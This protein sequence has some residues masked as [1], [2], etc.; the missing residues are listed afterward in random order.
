MEIQKNGK[1][2]MMVHIKNKYIILSYTKVALRFN[3]VFITQCVDVSNH[4]IK[5][6]SQE[7]CEVFIFPVKLSSA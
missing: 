5:R 3:V 2:N 7:L 1:A 4:M 6:Y